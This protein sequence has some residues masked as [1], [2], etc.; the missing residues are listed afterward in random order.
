MQLPLNFTT[1]NH[2]ISFQK[3]QEYKSEN[4]TERCQKSPQ[5]CALFSGY[6]SLTTDKNSLKWKSKY[7]H[8]IVLGPNSANTIAL[9]YT[10]GSHEHTT[11]RQRCHG[12]AAAAA[13]RC[14]RGAG[15]APE[16]ASGQPRSQARPPQ[17]SSA[18]HA[19][20]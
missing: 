16:P 15:G 2:S 11:P 6:F 13:A 14:A 1:E 12:G 7:Y 17:P 5:L 4:A 3:A 18:T 19:E 20:C 8:L 10:L 9:C